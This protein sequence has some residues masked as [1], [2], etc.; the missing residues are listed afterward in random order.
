MMCSWQMRL[1][2]DF[3]L[4]PWG[5]GFSARDGHVHLFFRSLQLN[6]L[7]SAPNCWTYCIISATCVSR[8]FSDASLRCGKSANVLILPM[9]LLVT[10]LSKSCIND[11]NL[12][13]AAKEVTS[14]SQFFQR[15]NKRTEGQKLNGLKM[16]LRILIL[17]S[18]K[19]KNRGLF[20]FRFLPLTSKK[21]WNLFS[22]WTMIFLV[23]ETCPFAD[24]EIRD[25]HRKT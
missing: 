24:E 5:R 25:S 4:I 9:F 22:Q 10:N 18:S 1:I 14:W 8:R 2:I 20:N 13:R 19:F 11:R 15:K 6:L 17:N 23:T 3:F 7:V 21:F 12:K 16:N